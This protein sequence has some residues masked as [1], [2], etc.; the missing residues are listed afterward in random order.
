MQRG[1]VLRRDAFEKSCSRVTFSNTWGA[2]VFVVNRVVALALCF[3][4][5]R[6]RPWLSVPSLKSYFSV[7]ALRRFIFRYGGVLGKPILGHNEGPL[8][9][10]KR[11]HA[12]LRSFRF[13]P[14]RSHAARRSFL[15]F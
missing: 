3:S 6:G 15:D 4:M 5:I 1:E 7:L 12:A 8:I 14:E 9:F 11:S 2:T 13:A 10:K